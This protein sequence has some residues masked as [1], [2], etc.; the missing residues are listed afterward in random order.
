MDFRGR[1]EL[2]VAGDRSDVAGRLAES[3]DEAAM[4]RSRLRHVLVV[5]AR[6]VLIL[7]K[8]AMIALALQLL[9]SHFHWHLFREAGGNG[10][11]AST[12]RRAKIANVELDRVC[13]TEYGVAKVGSPG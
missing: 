1:D 6:A 10:Y 8:S 5:S 7:V 4:N 12:T 3:A 11:A 2:G 9:A 13:P